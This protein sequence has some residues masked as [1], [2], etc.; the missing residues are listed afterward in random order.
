MANVAAEYA[1]VRERLLIPLAKRLQIHF[2]SLLKDDPRID[3]V[4]A[5]AKTVERFAEKA[6]KK[7]GDGTPKY[8][9][10]LGQIQDM[11]GVRIVTFYLSD[12]DAIADKVSS[13][14]QKIEEKALIPDSPDK[15][16]YEGKH[17]IM[18]IPRD[19]TRE[20]EC[21]DDDPKFFELQVKT[22]FQHAWGEASHDLAYKS[23]TPLTED[24]KR[25]VAYAAAQ[26]WGG[27]RIFQDLFEDIDQ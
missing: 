5:R 13:Y 15:F 20:D 17:F 14:F 26:A 21:G 27:D 3:R 10:P 22:L 24:Q 7:K 1:E 4:S 9:D 6:E 11:V 2:E 16:G 19:V 23:P 8:D 18:F 25:R 12:V